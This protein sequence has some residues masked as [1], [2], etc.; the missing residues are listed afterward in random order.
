MN[1][2]SEIIEN[3]ENDE[4]AYLIFKNEEQKTNN[5]Y[6]LLSLNNSNIKGINEKD[7][8]LIISNLINI[9]ENIQNYGIIHRDLKADNILYYY[10]YGKLT[11]SLIDFGMS[12]FLGHNEIIIDEPIGTLLYSAP[13]VI[14]NKNYNIKSESFSIGVLTYLLLTGQLPFQADSEEKLC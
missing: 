5:L 12:K 1:N 7:V 9:L 13:E 2:I 8:K 14:L 3:Y 10:K 11:I 4:F 6:S